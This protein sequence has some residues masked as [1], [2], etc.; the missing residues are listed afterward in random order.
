[1]D[2][3][4][5]LRVL[6]WHVHGNYLYYL[7]Q[8]PHTFVLPVR[9]LRP[10]PYAGRTRSFPWGD[11]VVEVPA[12][13]LRDER[14]DV[15]LFQSRETFER[16][17]YTYLTPAQRSLPRLYLEHDPPR[18]NPTDTRHVVD[19]PEVPV[20]HV[21]RFNQLMWDCGRSPTLVIPHGVL[22]PP[23][24]E[25]TGP[26]ERGIVVVNNLRSRGRRLGAD[27][28]ERVRAA[29]VP[30]DLVGMDARSIGG[31]GEVPPAE[32]AEFIAP[33]RFFFNPIRYTSL[34][35]SV[36]EAMTLG[37]PVVGL[38]TTEMATTVENGVSGYVDNDVDALIER[39]RA[40]I[41]DP[42]LAARLGAGARAYARRAFA[43]DRFVADWDAAL[44]YAVARAHAP[45]RVTAGEAA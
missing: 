43:L 24:T 38:A 20:V 22:V 4:A 41:A 7:S 21:T 12:D 36:C 44:R 30:L 19:D 8:A 37:M 33:Y 35:L 25:Y 14:F 39:M 3:A 23:Y 28:F 5:P 17:Q 13:R 15:I 2:H 18:E 11:N 45:W 9:P 32:L 1:M 34:G 40:L 29:G 16:D 6:T 31:I 42:G 10:H 27:I 26:L